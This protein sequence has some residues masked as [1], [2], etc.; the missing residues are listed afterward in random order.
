MKYAGLLRK[1][2]LLLPRKGLL[3]LD[4]GSVTYDQPFHDSL[5]KKL[6]QSDVVL[7]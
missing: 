5:S 3:H 6:N 2:Q 4:Y 7:I 1:L